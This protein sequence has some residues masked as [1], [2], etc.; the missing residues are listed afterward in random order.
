MTS[1]IRKEVLSQ[2]FQAILLGK[3]TFELRLADWDCREGDVLILEEQDETT[4]EI[5]GRR[6]K[7]RVGYVVHTKD[8]RLWP[9]EDADKYGYQVI[10]LL[11][12]VSG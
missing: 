1:E 6:L 9:P 7:K 5:T 4:K 10:S 3:K 2:Y 11:D 12:E 8:L